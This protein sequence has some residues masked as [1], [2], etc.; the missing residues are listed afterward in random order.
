MKED[1]SQLQYLTQSDLS[2][3]FKMSR[4]TIGKYLHGFEPDG[5]RFKYR[6]RYPAWSRE[7][8]KAILARQM[9][10]P[11]ISKEELLKQA[12]N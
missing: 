9:Q 5:T 7:Y 12:N 6:L 2:K 11:A 8:F 1:L 10:R 3:E 4:A